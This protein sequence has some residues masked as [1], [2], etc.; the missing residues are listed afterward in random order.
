V[1][2]ASFGFSYDTQDEKL[3]LS[4]DAANRR[5]LL[6]TQNRSSWRIEYWSISIPDVLTNAT[7]WRA[8]KRTLALDDPAMATTHFADGDINRIPGFYGKTRL[9]SRL[10]VILIPSGWYRTLGFVPGV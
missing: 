2:L 6:V 4:W 8:V 5:V 1:D 3:G 7:G 9:H 10:G